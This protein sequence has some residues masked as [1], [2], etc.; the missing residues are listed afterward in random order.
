MLEAIGDNFGSVYKLR[1]TSF[2]TPSIEMMFEPL[3]HHE[4]SSDFS[5]L[6]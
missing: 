2:Q 1:L 4:S 3:N 5:A 6:P